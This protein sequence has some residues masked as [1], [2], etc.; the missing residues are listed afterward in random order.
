M[1][2]HA[3]RC[4]KLIGTLR[5][6]DDAIFSEARILSPANVRCA[7]IR[8]LFYRPRTDFVPKFVSLNIA[9]FQSEPDRNHW[10]RVPKACSSMY[11]RLGPS[12]T[13]SGA[14]KGWR[15]L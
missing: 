11:T 9:A 14:R 13:I 5:L 7:Q 8:L 4:D 10:G 6:S 15:W 2:P 3:V 12:L 1:E